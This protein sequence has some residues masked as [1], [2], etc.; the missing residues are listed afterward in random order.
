MPIN[1]A[2]PTILIIDEAH[3]PMKNPLVCAFIVLM[4][5]VARKIGL[6][7]IPV[8]QNVEDFDGTEAK[9]CWR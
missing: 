8:T 7:L 6:W 9:K 1:A 2:R 5:K 4:A 3:I